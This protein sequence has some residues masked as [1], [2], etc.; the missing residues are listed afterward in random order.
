MLYIVVRVDSPQRDIAGVKEELAAYC[1]R[2]GDIRA[3]EVRQDE[4]RQETLF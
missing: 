1:E 3:V 2:Y 4:P